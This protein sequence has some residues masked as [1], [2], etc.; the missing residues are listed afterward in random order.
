M[1]EAI[2]KAALR[3]GFDEV[4]FLSPLP[5]PAWRDEASRHNTRAGMEWDIP[6][7]YPEATCVLLLVASYAPYAQETRILPYYLREN[8]AYFQTKALVKELCATGYIFEAA[9]LPARA[10]ALENGVGNQLK[11]G[12]LSLPRYGT[13]TSLFTLATNACAPLSY[14]QNES[15]CPERCDA[16]ARACPAGAIAKDG[17]CVEKC[18]RYHMDGAAHPPF[19]LEK[20]TSFL[21]CDA[22]QRAC[23]KNARLQTTEPPDEARAAFDL[24]RLIRGETKEARALAGKNFTGGGKLTVEAIALA[25]REGLHEA[26]IRAALSSPHAAVRDAAKWA[27]ERYF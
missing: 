1:R 12:L 16:C 13:R 5:L 10:L 15:G 2:E 7:A 6:S 23:P 24:I 17:L 4:Y 9:W 20:F 8:Q 19:V 22:C 27:L 21:G 11:S 26:D 14:Q 25:A 18:L 3:H